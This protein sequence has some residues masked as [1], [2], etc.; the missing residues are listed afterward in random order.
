MT[1]NWVTRRKPTKPFLGIETGAG[2]SKGIWI[3]RRK[4]TKP[5]LGIETYITMPLAADSKVAN[6]LNPS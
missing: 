2:A 5:F 6:Q 3:L 1:Q 4:P